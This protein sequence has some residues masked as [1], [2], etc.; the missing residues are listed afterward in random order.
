MIK[1]LSTQRKIITIF[2]MAEAGVLASLKENQ[3]KTLELKEC[4]TKNKNSTHS[5]T[6]FIFL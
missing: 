4:S 5:F 2:L 1:N 6:P 3:I